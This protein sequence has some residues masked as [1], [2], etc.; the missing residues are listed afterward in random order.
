VS[1]AA[2]ALGKHRA[3]L[4]GTEAR[5]VVAY[6][7]QH[8]RGHTV[9]AAD[10]LLDRPDV[11]DLDRTPQAG[12]TPTQQNAYPSLT[13]L[14]EEIERV[15]RLNGGGPMGAL[16]IARAGDAAARHR[17]QDDSSV[18]PEQIH[19]RVSKHPALFERTPDGIRLRDT[20][21]QDKAPSIESATDLTAPWFWEGNVQATVARFLV[22]E[23]WT[24]ESAAD[25]A[26]RQRGIDLIARKGARRL[27]V[28]VKGYPG[29]VYARGER[30]GQPKPTAP[31]TQARHWFAQALLTAVLTGG[32]VEQEIALAFP[33]MPRFRELIGRSEWALGCLGIRVLLVDESGRV[34]ELP[35]S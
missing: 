30:A 16:S 32:S 2:E 19:A 20:I 25:T 14:H 3:A 7:A 22:A 4:V 27:A 33:D 17:K 12:R 26:S 6:Y 31:T 10:D 28:E 29:T 11:E 9:C 15:L 5:P 1:A 23:G 35:R 13:T 24:I 21:A 8:V 34:E 18:A